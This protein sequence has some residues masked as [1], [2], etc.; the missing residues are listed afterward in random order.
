MKRILLKNA[1]VVNRG[2]SR[3]VDILINNDRIEKIDKQISHNNEEIHDLKGLHVIPGIIDD[4][5]HFREPGLTYK[6]DIASESIAA[7]AGGVT[8][9][10]EMPNT[11]PAAITQE[12]LQNKYDIASQNS[13]VNYSFFM[14]AS[15]DN[16]EEVL[17]TNPADVCGV[18]IFMGSS[19]GNMLVD[20]EKA[21]AGIFGGTPMLIAT[22]C[23]DEA[24]IAKNL[25]VYKEK[26]GDDIPTICHPLI[27]NDLGCYKS[28]SMAIDLAKKHGSRLHIL[29][30][31]TAK[32]IE[33]FDNHIPL[34]DKKI[35]AEVCVH[36]LF[37]D[38][39]YYYALGN[40]VKCNPAIKTVQDKEALLEGLKNGFFDV[41]ATDHA[42]HT[43]EEKQ[44]PYLQSPSGLPL[45]Q[46]SLSLML[47]FYHKGELSLEFIVNKMCHAPAELF[48]IKDRGYVEEGCFADLAVVDITSNLNI[49][50]SNILY[51]CGWSPLENFDLKGK[52]ISTM[53][54]GKWVFQNE[55]ITGIKSGE[56][57]QFKVS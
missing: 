11:K 38:E 40:K 50:K 47:D 24:T 23:E 44:K 29:H 43:M 49:N 33:L 5:V 12:L 31:S 10:M 48:R 45:I 37:F 4:Q 55:K 42:P 56:R 25:S 13:T 39:S 19:T 17:K 2:T 20:N 28:S 54:N 46:H 15:N 35:T 36:H 21:L 34:I 18:K 57:L 1:V 22:H 27:R 41:I 16:L 51:K 14:G 32:E 26:Y 3:T 6:A 9:F 52:V 30:I 8:S 7:A 53:C